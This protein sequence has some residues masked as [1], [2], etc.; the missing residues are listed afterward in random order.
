MIP[1]SP[2]PNLHPIRQA[3]LPQELLKA[4]NA[5]TGEERERYILCTLVENDRAIAG[6]ARAIREISENNDK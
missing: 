5:M 4:W 1:D 2:Y 3:M 6:L